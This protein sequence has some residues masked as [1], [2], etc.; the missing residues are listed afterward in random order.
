MPDIILKVPQLSIVTLINKLDGVVRHGIT[1]PCANYE[2]YDSVSK[3]YSFSIKPPFSKSRDMMLL[4]TYGTRRWR[5]TPVAVNKYYLSIEGE[6]SL[7]NSIDKWP[8]RYAIGYISYKIKEKYRALSSIPGYKRTPRIQNIAE[9]IWTD[10]DKCV[11]AL[12]VINIA[13]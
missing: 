7:F 13:Y 6:L 2:S 9:S 4:E 12:G 11:Q 1:L 5:S 10:L 3:C 8:E